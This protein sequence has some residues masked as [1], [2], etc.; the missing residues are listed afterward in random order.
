MYPLWRLPERVPGVPQG[1]RRGVRA[2]VLG[3]DGGGAAA[4]ARRAARGAVASARLLA[5][6]RLHRGVPREDP[7]ARAAPG[8]SS[9][10]RRGGRG[11]VVGAAG[12]T[13]WSWAWSSALGYRASTALARLGQPLG[14]LAGP[15]RVWAR[16]R[17]LPRF[18]RRYRDRAREPGRRLRRERGGGRL[19]RPP[20]RRAG[21]RRCGR[22][23]GALRPGGHGVGRA[24]GLAG[25]AACQLPPPRRARHAAGGV[26]D[27]ARARRALRSAWRRSPECARDRH[28]PE[29]KRRHRAEARG[30]C[31]R[32]P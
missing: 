26:A 13:L 28:R 10:S 18:G 21:A 2:G 5:V 16:G 23:A 32:S 24:G 17:S 22:L 31:S 9:R 30:R 3:A 11:A 14:G 6:R 29:P 7:A 8:P 25:R 12:F 20:R 27:P 19:P 1:R 4:A 15:G